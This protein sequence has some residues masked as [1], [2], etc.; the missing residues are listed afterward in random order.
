MTLSLASLISA[1]NDHR[2][3]HILDAV[4]PI[5]VVAGPMFWNGL[6]PEIRANDS[7][8][9]FKSQLKTYYF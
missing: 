9:S 3:I 6:P 1:G 2:P 5:H 8:Q 7:L 4:P